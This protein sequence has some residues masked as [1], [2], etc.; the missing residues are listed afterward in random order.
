MSSPRNALIKKID[1]YIIGKFLSTFFFAIMILAVISCVIDYSEKVDNIVQKKAPF[2]VVLNYYKNFVPHITALLFPLFIFIATIF[3]TSKLAYKSEIIAILSSGV[4]FQRFLRPYFIGGGFLCL[5]SLLANHWVIPI[6]NKQR[7][8]FEDKYINDGNY[9]YPG[10]NVHLGISKDAFI[11]IQSFN[12][13]SG[14]GSHFTAEK[15]KGNILAE[16]LMAEVINYDS[17]KKIWILHNV[18]IRRND[19]LKESITTLPELSLNYPFKPA[20]LNHNEA[21]KEGLT[22]PELNRFIETETL[23][24]RE[25][26]NFFYVEKHRRTAQP[27]A[28]L[29]LTVI[30]ACIASRKIRGGGGLHLALGIAISAIYIMLMQLSTTFSTKSS[31]NP[32]IAV[33]I[34][35][36][37]F[38]GVAWVLYKRQVK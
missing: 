3:F 26:L 28:G 7:V 32:M 13:A 30:G 17:V 10:E 18:V 36:L 1:W 24:G 37:I 34:P 11:Y 31:L 29:I 38:A 5:V 20:D 15:M 2:L 12:F 6:A 21:Q 27:F 33:W 35:N 23:R 19:T 9:I 22:T 4:S 14:T 8:A 25:N 16:K